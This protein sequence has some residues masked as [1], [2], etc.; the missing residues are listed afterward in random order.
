[1]NKEIWIKRKLTSECFYLMRGSA[2]IYFDEIELTD[3]QIILR[4][5]KNITAILS[6][7]DTIIKDGV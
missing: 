7:F 1:M 6:K 5:H 2:S 4:E 3:C